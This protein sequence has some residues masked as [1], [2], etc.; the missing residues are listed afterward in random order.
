MMG[1]V[2]GFAF[3]ATC[4]AVALGINSLFWTHRC[5]YVFGWALQ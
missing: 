2:Y 5:S 3:G 4:A 1:V